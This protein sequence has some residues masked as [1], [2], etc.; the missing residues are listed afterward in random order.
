[1]RTSEL[2]RL[3]SRQASLE[4]ASGNMEK[5]QQQLSTGRKISV[6]SDDAAGAALALAHR[7]NI[8]FENQMRRNLESG[9][10]V[11]NAGEAA[12]GSGT[13]LLQRARE[14]TV[15]ASSGTLSQSDRLVVAL[16]I[17]QIIAGLA[18][19][20]NTQFGGA[21]LFSGHKSNAPAY[22][23][24][25]TP[26][27][28]V[29]YQGDAGQRLRRVSEQD[30]VA[31][32]VTGG[33][34]FGATFDDLIALRDDLNGAAPASA[35]GAHLTTLDDGLE[36]M[37]AARAALGARA[38]RFE[39]AQGVSEQRNVGLQELRSS[40]EEI[41]LPST[42]VEFTAAQNALEAALGAIGRT[43]SMTLL[44]FLR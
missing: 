27:T 20:G 8:N 18:Q 10:A 31:V 21:Y 42:I 28:S 2:G 11:L 24:V 17:D 23:V 15:S 6:A 5:V 26:P 41:D 35:I 37:I 43:S 22:A 9:R 14:L 16:E 34:A 29:T 39:A 25:G 12:L 7:R 19:L 40:I 44:D 32:N 3:Y 33:E 13:D 38:N 1:M 36:R 4:R 30:T